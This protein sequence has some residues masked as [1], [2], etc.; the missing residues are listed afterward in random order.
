MPMPPVTSTLPE[1]SSVAVWVCVRDH[2]S[3]RRR[4]HVRRRVVQHG[5]GE[6]G[7]VITTCDQQL[8]RGGKQGRGVACAR[9][10]ERTGGRPRIHCRRVKFSAGEIAAVEAPRLEHVAQRQQCRGLR[11]TRGRQGARWRPGIRHRPRLGRENQQQQKN[12]SP[13]NSA[14]FRKAAHK[15]SR[16]TTH[17]IPLNPPSAEAVE[18]EDSFPLI[19]F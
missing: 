7:T 16:A 18:L 6:R 15:Q 10:K 13:I 17:G 12:H 14:F 11:G 2:E 9:R 5:A 3:A 1:A 8:A 4:P 19:K